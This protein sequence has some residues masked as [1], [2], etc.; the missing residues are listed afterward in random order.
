MHVSPKGNSDNVL[1]NIPAGYGNTYT[2]RIPK[3]MPNGLYWYH[4]HLH[5]VTAAETYG[6][7][8]GMLE[9]GRPDGRLPAVT[10]H[11]LPI[12]TMAL[13]YNYVFDRAGGLAQLDNVN[14]PQYVSTLKKPQPG[15]LADGT[16]EPKLTPV[17]FSDSAVGTNF[18]T[19]WYTGPLSPDND[20]GQFQFLPSNLETFT[21]ND[22]SETI[23]ADPSLPDAKRDLQYT[24]NGQFQPVMHAKPGQTEIWVLANMSDFAYM[25]VSLTNTATGRHPPFEIVGQDGNPSPRVHHP[26]GGSRTLLLP[27]ATRY[28]I[29]VTMP[30]HGGLSLEM[31]PQHSPQAKKV[32]DPAIAYTND[33]TDHPPAKLGTVSI[34]PSAISYYD[35]FLYYPTQQLAEVKPRHGHGQGTTV[36]FKPGQRTRTYTSFFNASKVQPDV[37]RRFVIS[38]GFDN[39]YANTND[40]KAFTYDFD[41]NT[42]PNVPLIQPRLGS[43]EQWTYVNKN[44]D[45]HPIH[46]HVNDFQVVR[47]VDPVA[48]TTTGP[49]M[50]AQDNENVPSPKMNAKGNKVVAPGVMSLRTKFTQF[51]GTYVVHCHRLNHEDNGL[52]GLI[53]VIP[54]ISPYAVAVPGTSRKPAKVRIHD[55]AGD[56]RLATVTPFPG[57][58]GTPSVAVGDVNGDQVLDLIAGTGKGAKSKVVAYSGKATGG[59]Q[60]F[61]RVLARFQPFGRNFRGGVNVA[62][63]GI[64][65]NPLADNIVV[66]SGPGRESTVKVFSTGLPRVGTAPGVWGSFTPYAGSESGVQV[67]TGLVD[68]M[69]GRQS[70]V[71]APGPGN[72]A[73]IKT[74]RYDLLTPNNSHSGHTMCPTSAEAPSDPVVT[75]NFLAFGPGYT[76]G[77]SLATGW[78]AGQRAARSRS[79]P[80]SSPRPAASGSTRAARRSKGNRSCTS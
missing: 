33:G 57:F 2:Y 1:L 38:G 79:S 48:G 22:G 52:M 16:Y 11:S 76:G 47:V 10:Q 53:N 71:T 41:A 26:V 7:L 5:Q 46:I 19:V 45:Q 70:I 63:A 17:N 37:R 51:T 9:I 36:P 58:H 29:A 60:S 40:P 8:A 69:S 66:G 78:V 75:S 50:W 31:P 44:N 20:R 73:R 21:A 72:P 4:S 15:Q 32:S 59:A 49:Q 34:K 74:F 6:G 25:N 68:A 23:P 12:R 39:N 18:F 61:Q 56:R 67:A 65:G 3:S 13:Q 77:V 30:K 54:K 28:A 55:Q 80:A 64:D 42:F 62:A 14:W 24:V 35:G 43:V 27:P